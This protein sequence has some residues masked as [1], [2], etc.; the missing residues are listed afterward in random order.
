MAQR[1]L[2]TE[3]DRT[4][5]K[6]S[7]GVELFESMYDKLQTSNNQTQKEKLEVDLKT[8]IKKLQRMRDSIK[9][10]IS[11]S[12]IK[13]K[14]ELMSSRK[15]IETQMERFKACEKEIKTKAFSKEG[16]IAAT[17]LDPKD[18]VKHE[19]SNWLGQ[20]VD[21]LSRQIET[22]EAEIEHISGATSKRSKKSS[23]TQERVS[24]LENLNERRNWHIS[25]LE[26]TLRLLENDQLSVDQ[27]N[28]IKDDIQYFVE[29]NAEEEF[30]EDEGIY[31]ELNLDE[32]EQMY[33]MGAANSQ[34]IDEQASS[35]DSISITDEPVQPPSKP[36]KKSS[37]DEDIATPKKIKKSSFTSPDSSNSGAIP[38]PNFNQE[39]V[40][41]TTQSPAS[42]Q[43]KPAPAPPTI[44]YATAAA[45]AVANTAV[46]TTSEGEEQIKESLQG[47]D[48][49]GAG[50]GVIE[51]DELDTPQ[52]DTQVPHSPPQLQSTTF[53]EPT[54][55]I[56]SHP[57]SHTQPQTSQS[58]ASSNGLPYVLSDLA[59]SFET[60]KQKSTSNTADRLHQALESSVDGIPDAADAERPRYYVP[61]NLWTSPSYYPQVPKKDLEH[62][63]L[64]SRLETDTLF[65]IFYYMQG[66]YQQYLAA[67][68]LKKQSWR[69]HK[70]YL[71]WFQR[72]SEPSQITDDYEQGAYIYFDWEGTWC[73]RKKNDFKFDYVYLEDTLQ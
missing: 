53:E 42:L 66:T 4:L 31:D 22:T 63:S 14:S 24:E 51:G 52:Q 36:S 72:H 7:E 9:T 20:F 49:V 8:Q 1:K 17:R 73:E 32:E 41:R 12:D 35:H 2:L 33:G 45:N 46:P 67:R 57:Q 38:A 59:T 65:Y 70:Q 48:G 60:A 37:I 44:K 29:S 61:K 39:P 25:R 11:S 15:L 34:G 43:A 71:T 28:N 3:V 50:V 68:E 21:E 58:A 26:L 16:L 64:F 19:C 13:D 23:G 62:P 27:I 30:E 54:T 47:E 6:V 5:K 18:Q 40:A 10:W 55:Q 56:Q 69:F